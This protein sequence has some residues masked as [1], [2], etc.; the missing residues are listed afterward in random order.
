MPR[1]VW[2]SDYEMFVD[3]ATYHA[4]KA[5]MTRRSHL[6][7][8]SVISDTMDPV[9]SMLDGRMYDSK[10]TLRQTYREGGV[11]E[12]GNDVPTKPKP[13]PAP[14]REGIKAAVGRAF[15]QAGL[16]A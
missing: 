9:K 14:D 5:N 12:V 11:T 4:A 8:P 2:D 16:G 1:Y 7:A 15:S 6:A 10:S 3:A 13:K